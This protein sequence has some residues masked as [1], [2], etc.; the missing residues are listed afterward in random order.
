MTRTVAVVCGSGVSST[1]LA[2]GLRG[3][4][5][6][7]SLDWAVEPLSVDDLADRADALDL[8]IVGHHL[9]ADAD[10]VSAA[11]GG[12]VPAVVLDAPGTGPDAVTAALAHLTSTTS[13]PSEGEHHG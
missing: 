4:I 9:A 2:R 5:A 6:D 8:V 7:R 12:R 3:A 13:A 1:F 10:A 11:L